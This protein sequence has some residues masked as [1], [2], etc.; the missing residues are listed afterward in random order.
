M[1]CYQYH[2]LILH[3]YMIECL[4]LHD[5]L[6]NTVQNI[7][8]PPDGAKTVTFNQKNHDHF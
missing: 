6:Q 1:V 7:W 3:A 8:Q 2:P 5:S 4:S